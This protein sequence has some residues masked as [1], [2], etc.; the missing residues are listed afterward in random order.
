M[1]WQCRFGQKDARQAGT[2]GDLLGEVIAC[3]RMHGT[4]GG[5]GLAVNVLCLLGIATFGTT[6]S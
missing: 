2:M 5:D 4:Y 1:T 6:T 3:D